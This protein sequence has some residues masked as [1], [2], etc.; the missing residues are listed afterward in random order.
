MRLIT[1]IGSALGVVRLCEGVAVA[2]RG[3]APDLAARAGWDN[4]CRRDDKCLN[5]LFNYPTKAEYICKKLLH[6][7]QTIYTTKYI[8]S[9]VSNILSDPSA[10]YSLIHRLPHTTRLHITPQ[11]WRRSYI[12]TFTV[13]ER[14]MTFCRIYKPVMSYLHPIVNKRNEPAP[15]TS[16]SDIPEPTGTVSAQAVPAIVG[17]P[18]PAAIPDEALFAGRDPYF[19]YCTTIDQ[20][21][22]ACECFLDYKHVPKYVVKTVYVT[23]K[24][25]FTPAICI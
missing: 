19:S 18:E 15:E 10:M 21:K 11:S 23:S 25:L 12:S 13:F 17:D 20:L 8:P 5:A 3:S 24:L 14:L 7:P 16:G 2:E 4:N 1:L 6:R 22:K 9:T